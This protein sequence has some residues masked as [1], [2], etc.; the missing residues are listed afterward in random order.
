MIYGTWHQLTDELFLRPI[1]FGIYFGGDDQYEVKF[2]SDLI[3]RLLGK[4]DSKVSYEEAEPFTTVVK[5][6]DSAE[7]KRDLHFKVT[8]PVEEGMEKTVEWFKYLCGNERCCS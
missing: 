3:L 4:D 1:C 5:T 8:V 2:I 6:P 7:A